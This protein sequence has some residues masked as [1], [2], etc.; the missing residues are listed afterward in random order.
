M[1]FSQLLLPAFRPA[2]F[3]PDLALFID[4]C[5]PRVQIRLCN[6]NKGT[7]MINLPEDKHNNPE[8]ETEIRGDKALH[9]ERFEDREAIE[10]SSQAANND[11]KNRTVWLE[12]RSP[13]NERLAVNSLRFHSAVPGDEDTDHARVG[14]YEGDGSQINEPEENLDGR[15]TSHEEGNARQNRYCED[16]VDR[17][18]GCSTF[19]KELRRLA[20]ASEGVEC[21]TGAVKVGITTR[22]SREQDQEVDQIRQATDTE[23]LDSDNPGRSS[24]AS[25][26]VSNGGHETWVAGTA[27]DAYS[28]DSDDIE[29]NNTPE[30]HLRN[31]GDGYSWVL[32]FSC[33]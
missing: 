9:T 25:G 11:S 24:G 14:E 12:R 22:P 27:D 19:Q 13:W 20:V 29:S 31:S 17:N 32:D 5:L 28:Q 8:C 16:T 18:T 7:P 26:T 33:G 30:R 23:V 3:F 15:G 21:S 1:H 2:T 4:L 6:V 10:Y